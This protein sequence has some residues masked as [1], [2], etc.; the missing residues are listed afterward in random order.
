M[1][2]GVA[3]ELL[4]GLPPGKFHEYEVIV[5]SGSLLVEPSKNTAC[6]AVIVTFVEGL[7][8]IPVGGTSA[9]AGVN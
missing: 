9:G 5:P 4:L 1:L 3:K 6:P 7:E 8:M 2:P